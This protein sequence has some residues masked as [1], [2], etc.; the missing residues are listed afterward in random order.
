[1][2]DNH[3]IQKKIRAY[4]FCILFGWFGYAAAAQEPQQNVEANESL[5]QLQQLQALQQQQQQ[6]LQ[7]QPQQQLPWEVAANQQQQVAPQPQQ[8][9]MPVQAA[10]VGQA[11]LA[12]PANP[13]QLPANFNA[14]QPMPEQQVLQADP[15]E[16]MEEMAFREALRGTFPLTPEQVIRL[17][18]MYEEMQLAEATSPKTPP[19]PTATSQQVNLSPGATPPVIRLA[20]G[21]VSSLVFLDSTGAEWPITAY[22]LGDPESFNIQWDR[23]S[24]TLMI[25]ATELYTHGNLAVRLQGLTTPVMLTLTPGQQAVDYRVDLRIQ[26][27]GP[28][29]AQLPAGDGLPASANPLLLNVLDGIP[30]PDSTELTVTGG[31]AQVWQHDDKLYVRTRLNVLSPAWLATMSSAD[32][33]RVYEMNKAP[34][35]LASQQGKV[36]QLK[37][38]GL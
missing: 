18:E 5:Q 12:L 29:A 6:Q 1:M 24:N 27:L 2:M 22:D 38:E 14:V 33:T 37:V 16:V 32:G 28:N 9:Q 25:Q 4:A 13:N 10:G 36:V 34:I 31:V 23:T 17:R 7:Q 8:Q 15:E 3:H 21:F 26:G 19:R 20:K 35:L 11:P 30:P